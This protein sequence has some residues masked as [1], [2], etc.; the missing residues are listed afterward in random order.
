VTDEYARVPAPDAANL[1][2]VRPP[3]VYLVAIVLGLLGHALWPERLVQRTFGA[4]AGALLVLLAA[5]LF[6]SAVRTLK[7]AGTPVPGNQPTKRIVHV[8]P[9]RFTR[10]PIY[11]AFTLLQLGVALVINSAA[12]LIT[13]VPAFGLMTFVV[14]PREER[15]LA[16]RFGSEYSAYKNR[17][18]RWL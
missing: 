12:V 17:V 13:L 16:A 18:R 6:G 7:A 14:V 3:R 8:G 15:Y 10:N 2:W 11:L 9:Y 4:I 5:A 1:G